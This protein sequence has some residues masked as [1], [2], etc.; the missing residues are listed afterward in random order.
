MHAFLKNEPIVN[1]I[2][3]DTINDNNN[4]NAKMNDKTYGI[5]IA[6]DN[7]SLDNDDVKERNL[8]NPFNS[9]TPTPTTSNISNK[10]NVTVIEKV[11]FN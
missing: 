8:K 10:G 4:E 6:D 2:S 11:S 9:N 7:E 3:T 5:N 1:V